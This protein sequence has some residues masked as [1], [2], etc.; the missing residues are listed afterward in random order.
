[1]CDV[2]GS[3]EFKRRADDTAETVRARLEAYHAQTAPIIPYYESKGLLSRVD[4]MAEMDEVTAQ[5]Q[6]V[7]S[8]SGDSV[9]EGTAGA[10][11]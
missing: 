7:L 1:M 2:C 9:P 10:S 6:S 4:G 3:T 8:K 11:V 5:I